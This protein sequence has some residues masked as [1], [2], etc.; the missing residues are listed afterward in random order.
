LI[1]DDDDEPRK[2]YR[3]R[4][5]QQ[6]SI[7]APLRSD[8]RAAT[9][10]SCF[11]AEG[12]RCVEWMGGG[13]VRARDTEEEAFARLVSKRELGSDRIGSNQTDGGGASSEGAGRGTTG[14]DDAPR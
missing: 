10:L 3:R 14:C 6:L 4:R 9:L 7:L 8:G 13:G 11:G 12:N 5:Q 2:S 1:I